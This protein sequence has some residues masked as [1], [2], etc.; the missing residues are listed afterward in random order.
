MRKKKSPVKAYQT[1]ALKLWYKLVKERDG[2]CQ[3]GKYYP[4]K[5]YKSP[6]LNAH[7]I[8]SKSKHRSICLDIENGILLCSGCHTALSFGND[9]YRELVREIVVKRD[10]AIYERLFEQAQ[11][12]G[13]H[14]CWKSISWLEDQIKVL[15]ELCPTS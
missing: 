9:A 7:H 5:C 8:F 3:I 13:P 10:P 1:K 11:M 2:C 4:S 6:V 14:L 15:E 12:K